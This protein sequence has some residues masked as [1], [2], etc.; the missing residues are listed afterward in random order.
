MN[1]CGLGEQDSLVCKRPGC[2]DTLRDVKALTYHLHIHN[3]HD[4]LVRFLTCLSLSRVL[5]ILPCFVTHFLQELR[6]FQMRRSLRD[7]TRTDHAYLP[8]SPEVSPYKPHKRY[9]IL[10][11]YLSCHLDLILFFMT[12]SFRRVLTKISSCT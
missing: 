6:L 12:E 3:I 5:L 9:A 2:R 1:E 11:V 10:R 4:R 8:T 7:S